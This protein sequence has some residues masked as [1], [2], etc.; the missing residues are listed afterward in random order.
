MM[1]LFFY[2]MEKWWLQS[3]AKKPLLVKILFT[4]IFWQKSDKR[5]IY[6]MIYRDGKS[7]PSYIKRLTYQELRDN[8]TI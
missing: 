7:G 5:T 8:I 1:W 2:E 6:N 4:A 3:D